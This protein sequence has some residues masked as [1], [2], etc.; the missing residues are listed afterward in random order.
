MSIKTRTQSKKICLEA[1]QNFSIF[2]FCDFS[3]D[4]CTCS[5][6]VLSN[7]KLF[8]RVIKVIKK[9]KNSF[10]CYCVK[11][12]SVNCI[13]DSF[14]NLAAK[15]VDGSLFLLRFKIDRFYTRKILGRVQKKNLK[16]F[17]PSAILNRIKL[18]YPGPKFF[19]FPQ[20]FHGNHEKLHE[21]GLTKR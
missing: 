5:R 6:V 11:L 20:T 8:S 7:F 14:M 9:V 10:D 1:E 2:Y 13:S 12:E 4:D 16:I 17:S 15:R 19:I 3:A 21:R 18:M